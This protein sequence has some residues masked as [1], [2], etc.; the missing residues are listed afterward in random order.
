MTP[1]APTIPPQIAKWSPVA[2]NA[3]RLH[4]HAALMM[5]GA[6]ERRPFYEAEA[7]RDLREIAEAMGCTLLSP[8]A[9]L[10]SIPGVG[11]SLNVQAIILAALRAAHA[12][13][14][15]DL[16]TWGEAAERLM[17]LTRDEAMAVEA[18]FTASAQEAA[19]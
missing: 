9:G 5:H 16:D 3:A 1:R 11:A 2:T 13:A 7:E 14:S 15:G 18:A 8:G 17:D 10:I 4:A 19:E 12:Q 6:P